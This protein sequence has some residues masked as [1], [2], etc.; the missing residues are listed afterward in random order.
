MTSERHIDDAIITPFAS[1]LD[2]RMPKT[3]RARPALG[4]K[5]VNEE[6]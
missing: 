1:K 3:Q 2:R 4:K 5:T 6:L